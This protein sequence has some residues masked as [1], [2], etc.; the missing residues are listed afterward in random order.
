MPDEIRNEEKIILFL[1][2]QCLLTKPKVY[3]RERVSKSHIC[4]TFT[5]N[6]K[7]RNGL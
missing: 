4:V 2:L 1:F 5:N 6:K 3:K 7:V